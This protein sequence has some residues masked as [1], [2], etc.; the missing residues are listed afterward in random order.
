MNRNT[1]L[2]TLIAAFLPITAPLCAGPTETA[3]ALID[4]AR[5][6]NQTTIVLERGA[7]G[8]LT[9][10]PTEDKSDVKAETPSVPPKSTRG[11]GVITGNEVL[12]KPLNL[13]TILLDKPTREKID[14][15]R[16]AYINPPI[17]QEVEKIP[18][19]PPPVTGTG[20]ANKNVKPK[21]KPIYLPYKLAVSAVVIK[22][23]GSSLVRVN[24][25]YNQTNSKHITINSSH[26]SSKGVAF[27]VIDK[28][29]IVPVGSTLLPR[30][31]KVLPTYQMVQNEKI[32]AKQKALPKT[33]ETV[34]Q[35]TLEQV[36]ILT[37][38]R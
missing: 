37:N 35:D 36:K 24:G 19:P 31:S 16:A 17:V 14:R 34:A 32:K 25:K 6:V 20:V 29:Q 21:K 9:V 30:Q 33:K 3:N 1:Y 10:R 22:P 23:D 8:R 12:N 5:E 15:Q 38:N 26:T 13:Q 18:P 7:D 4:S 27:E 11:T 28:E 2:L